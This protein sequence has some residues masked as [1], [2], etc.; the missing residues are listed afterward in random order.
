M[1]DLLVKLAPEIIVL[2]E[3]RYNILRAVSFNQ[4]IGRRLLAEQLSLGERVVRAELDFLKNQQLLVSDLS[5]VSLTPECE[6][7]LPEMASLLHRV[8]GLSLLENYISQKTGLKRVVIVPGDVDKDRST[9]REL[10]KAVGRFIRDT[11]RDGWVIAVTGGTTMAEVARS[12]P[13]AHGKRQ[14]LVVPARGGLG[15]DVEIQANTIAAAIA[16]GLGAAY[17]LLHVPDGIVGG[18]LESLLADHKVQEVINLSKRANLLLHGIGIPQVMASRR[19][20]DWQELFAQ[21]EK[22][23]A[24][25]AFGCFFAADGSVVITT[26]TVGP[27]LEELSRLEMVAA[28][29]GGSSKAEAIMAVLKN[30]FVHTLFTDQGA[31]ERIKEI[32]EH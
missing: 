25:E 27:T 15:E 3:R 20:L 1:E 19:D 22:P 5:G 2:L 28:V 10:G 26:P 23:P 7:L 4:P 14:L 21:K 32:L 16:R 9:L 11:A 6:S 12:V 31:A 29:A 30:G 13:P 18:A 8:Q 24:G 17:R